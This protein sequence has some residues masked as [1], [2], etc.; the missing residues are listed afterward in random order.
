MK[1][2]GLHN[3]QSNHQVSEN[4]QPYNI[5]PAIQLSTKK[6]WRLKK[7]SKTDDEIKLEQQKYEDLEFS[8]KKIST[9]RPRSKPGQSQ[10]FVFVDLSPRKKDSKQKT[11]VKAPK[12]QGRVSRLFR[13]TS[14]SQETM[15]E[16]VPSPD[17]LLHIQDSTNSYSSP[18]SP[19]V[20]AQRP[21]Q[22][23]RSYTTVAQQ[24]HD[25]QR[26]RSNSLVMTISD[27]GRAVLQPQQLQQFQQT[28]FQQPQP[29]FQT[30]LPLS[31]TSSSS[32][33]SS[34][35][36]MKQHN[37]YSRSPIPSPKRMES[38]I[39]HDRFLNQPT[40]DYIPKYSLDPTS[41]EDEEESDALKAFSKVVK[42]SSGRKRAN[43]ASSQTSIQSALVSPII[44]KTLSRNHSVSSISSIYNKST[45]IS[46]SRTALLRKATAPTPIQTQDFIFGDGSTSS[47]S[48]FEDSIKFQKPKAFQHKKQISI[49]V[50]GPPLHIDGEDDNPDT[51]DSQSPFDFQDGTDTMSFP[52]T[53]MEDLASAPSTAFSMDRDFQKFEGND[54]LFDINA[55]INYDT[56]EFEQHA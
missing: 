18:S 39:T 23:K 40:F 11:D 32:D 50:L 21:A 47:N 35:N 55:F 25:E 28:Q 30:Q 31:A 42:R 9:R 17:L 22:L 34:L 33:L 15:R 51:D 45:R 20:L 7:Y 3:D 41:S 8:P 38:P 14:S 48:Y 2:P 52:A 53:D 16:D 4:Q 44:N 24:R 37:Y 56:Q 6:A 5:S 27:S 12:K 29:Q 49:S 54:D 46:P 13:L 36:T 10:E 19:S 26:T 43:T 1:V